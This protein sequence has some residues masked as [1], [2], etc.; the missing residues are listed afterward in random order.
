[1]FPYTSFLTIIHLIGL[2]LGTGAASVKLVLLLKCR[3][4]YM[5]IPSYLNVARP[6]TKVLILGMILLTLSG[7]LW[8]LNGYP[9][10]VILIIKLVLVL[11]LWVL[12]PVID[13]VVE[14]KFRALAPGPDQAVTSEFIR[15]LNNYLTIEIIA[16]SLFYIII[17][18]WILV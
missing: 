4:D 10:M 8:L 16:T 11:G 18:Y 2:A 17:L 7:I 3:N 15:A 9:L 12:G 5:F 1:M 14:P 6:I 13:N